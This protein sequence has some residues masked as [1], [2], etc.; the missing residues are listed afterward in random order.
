MA[1]GE[2]CVKDIHFTGRKIQMKR[3]IDEEEGKG[4]RGGDKTDF[5]YSGVD[6]R[7]L[8]CLCPELLL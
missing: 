4:V 5:Y 7:S 1:A 3:K 6:N 8:D 2:G